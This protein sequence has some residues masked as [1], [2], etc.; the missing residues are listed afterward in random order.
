MLLPFFVI[1]PVLIAVFLFVFSSVKAARKIAIVFQAAYAVFAF[2]LLVV[3]REGEIMAN[4]GDYSGFMGII[5]RADTLAA[6]F[7]LLASVIFFVSA[8]YALHDNNSRLFWFLL[9]LLEGALVGLFLTRDFFNVFVLVEVSTIVTTILLMYDRKRR[10]MF[11]GM[12]FIMVNIIVMQF[13]LFGL[14]YL[15]LFTGMLDFE[16]VAY[17]ISHMDEAQL[18]LPYALIMTSVAAKCSLMPMMIW[19]PKVNAMSGARSSI[20]AIISGLHIKSGVYLFIRV[21]EV[22]G[23]FAIA[24]RDFFMIIAV[25]TAFG[26]IILALSQNDMRKM[27][28]YSTVAQVSLILIGFNMGTETSNLGSLY[29]VINHAFFK[30]ALFLA[31]GMIIGRYKTKDITKI[32]GLWKSSTPLAFGTVISVLGMVGAPL[33]NGSISK[34][35][36]MYDMNGPLEWIVILINVGTIL[37]FVRFSTIFFGTNTRKLREFGLDMCKHGAVIGLGIACL[38]FGIFGVQI[39]HFLFVETVRIDPFGYLQKVG[40]FAASVGAA[41][42]LYRYVLAGLLAKETSIIGRL[43]GFDMGFKSL[44]ISI[45]VFF[46]VILGYVGF[47]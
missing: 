47:I 2:Y 38:L 39:I 32:R 43:N 31:A 35:L 44:C 30:A 8:V 37:V 33:F 28:A 22:F 21:Q 29:H 25:I 42:L 17:A 1:I 27:L 34:Y 14:G 11:A 13:Y 10:N 9:F 24:N 40:I 5:L 46:L 18:I 12:T 6:A 15:Y 23:D 4:V 19:L 41:I 20:S 36:L 26:A 16:P 7:I 3:A 45:G